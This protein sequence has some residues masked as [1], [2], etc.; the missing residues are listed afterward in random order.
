MLNNPPF[1]PAVILL[2]VAALSGCY[3]YINGQPGESSADVTFTLDRKIENIVYTNAVWPK[4]LHADLYLPQKRGLRPVVLMIHGG[5]WANRSRDD[6]AGISCKLVR[7]GYAVINVNY[8]FAPQ[9]TYP[10]QVHD[11]QQALSWIAGN[12]NRYRLDL[13]RVNTWGYSSGAHLA[14]LIGAIDHGDPL[15]ADAKPLPAIRSVVAGGIP[16]DLRKYTG[17]PIVIRFM[18]GDRDEMP[19]RY[20]EAS[21]AFH[22]SSD[23][24][25]VF[26]YHGKL[27]NL[28]SEDQASDYYEALRASDVDAELYL[29]RWR[30][31]MS[32]FLFGGDAED[33]AIGFLNRY[34]LT[35]Q[36]VAAE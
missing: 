24:P 3:T 34:N 21:P 29:H 1:I 15:A 18:G 26:L 13:E 7:Q 17:S 12:A 10:A 4:P 36:L 33:K 31:H 16:A 5:G 23:D 11:L 9:Y 14:A 8:R 22:I 20:A 19:E 35:S 30:G 28:V 6:M 32:M 27:D 25:P 2:A